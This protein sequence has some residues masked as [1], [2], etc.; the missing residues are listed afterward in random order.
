MFNRKIKNYIVTV[1]L[2]S[3]F[4]LLPLFPVRGNVDQSIAYLK[5]KT[6]NPWITMALSAVGENPD[7]DYL[8]SFVGASASDYEAAILA[9]TAAGK[10]PRSFPNENFVQKLKSFYSNGQIGD[11]S[12]LNDDIFGLLALLAAGEPIGDEVASGAKNFIV[13]NQK[14]DGGWAFAL[15]TGSDTNMTSMTLMALLEAGASKTDA[16]ISKAVGYLKDAQNSDGGFPYDPK[17]SFGTSSDASSDAWALSALNK[18]GEDLNGW[19]KDGQGP[20]EHLSGLEAPSGYFEFQKG[21]GEDAFSLVTTSYAV[22]ALSGKYYP[23]SKIALQENPSVSFKIE[24]KTKTYCKGEAQAPD[25]LEL[26]KIAASNCNFTY[27]IKDTSY[28]PY[29]E[30]I[31]D[32]KASGTDGWLYAVNFILPNIGAADYKLKIGD[33]VL[34]HFGEFD[35]QPQSSSVTLSAKVGGSAGNP[36]GDNQNPGEGE[37]SLSVSIPGAGGSLDFGDILPGESRT[38]TVKVTNSGN[39]ALTIESIVTGDD[40]FRNYLKVNNLSWRDFGTNLAPGVSEAEKV[41]VQ[42]PSSYAS[43]G[44]KNGLLIFWGTPGQ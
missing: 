6:P 25:A 22:I 4:V 10:D 18:L 8:K 39:V 11:P 24:G 37:I 32:D 33:Y 2:L 35:W 36:G 1:L 14:E 34:W 15:S 27:N 9:L 21:S 42:I 28:G 26:V 3:A 16:N 38:K 20:S 19:K 23:V 13:Q 30:Q 17:S 29:L 40:V 12:L 31:G 43:P 44:T 7:V 41:G 5:T